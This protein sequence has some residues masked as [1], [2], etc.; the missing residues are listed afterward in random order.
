MK[1][2]TYIISAIIILML[3]MPAGLQAQ[4][5]PKLSLQVEK[6]TDSKGLS[7]TLQIVLLLTVLALAPSILVMT[8][9]FIRIIIVLSFVRQALGTNQLPPSQLI[10]GVALVMTMFVMSPVIS[11]VHDKAWQPYMNGEI[12]QKQLYDEGM[13]PLRAFMLQQTREKDLA[14][15]VKFAGVQ[16]P[17]TQDDIPTHV[18]VPGFI[19]SELRT[20]FQISFIIFIPFLVIDMV[21]ASVLMSMGMMMLPP[22]LVALPFKILLFVMVDGWYLIV[23]SLLESFHVAGG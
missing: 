1:L 19:L 8:T 9:S 12:N 13:K 4:S 18:V 6:G 17:Q 16:K 11:Q 5:L 14:L 3:L 2:C 7:T 20:A 22:V 21:V 15:F 23:K 10:M